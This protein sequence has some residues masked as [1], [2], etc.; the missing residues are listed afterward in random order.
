[1]KGYKCSSIEEYFNK[2]LEFKILVTRKEYV[3]QFPTVFELGLCQYKSYVDAWLDHLITGDSEYT[4]VGIDSLWFV[5]MDACCPGIVFYRD[6]KDKSSKTRLRPDSTMFV[7]GAIFAKVEEKASSIDLDQA[8]I[9]L[10]SK[11]DKNAGKLFP[12]ESDKILGITASRDTIRMYS[13]GYQSGSGKFVSTLLKAYNVN[14]LE[15]RVSFIYD[16][17]RFMRFVA[18][19]TGPKE[20]FHL[21]PDIRMPTT[22]GHHIKWTNE[23]LI[24]EYHEISATQMARI[25]TVYQQRLPNVEYGDIFDE[26]TVI[27]KRIGYTLLDALSKQLISRDE[28]LIHV[29]AGI[30]QLHSLGLAHCDIKTHNVFVDTKAPHIAFLDDLEYLTPLADKPLNFPEYGRTAKDYDMEGYTS[31]RSDL[32]KG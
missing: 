8:A 11:F 9:E 6:Q 28:A 27:V 14:F 5:V 13:I 3:D 24:K 23:G 30:E 7:N 16:V 21:K 1:M 32:M 10:C 29:L 4:V 2:H 18:R 20:T 22:N 15:E 19:I 26:R 31:L 17:F 12:L 25:Q